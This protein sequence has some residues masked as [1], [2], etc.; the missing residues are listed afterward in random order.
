M[1]KP[2]IISSAIIWGF[3]FFL[4]GYNS[5]QDVTDAVKAINS[6]YSIP[7]V[8]DYESEINNIYHHNGIVTI[9]GKF[10]KS[11]HLTKDGLIVT[12]CHEAAHFIG[13]SIEG[14][15][16]YYATSVCARK[17]LTV[18]R[19]I[20]GAKSLSYTIAVIN[21]ETLPE[22][23][24]KDYYTTE[25]TIKNHTNAQCRFDT[26]IAGAFLKE[27]PRCWYKS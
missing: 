20:E 17:I 6:V 23:W 11:P 1:N 14:E 16:D 27:R 18:D 4:S 9:H 10:V 2:H 24:N 12:L 22:L 5:H 7:I 19:I 8:I 13:I 15:A 25:K 3:S 21:N 26:F